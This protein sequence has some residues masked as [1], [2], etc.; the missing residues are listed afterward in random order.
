MEIFGKKKFSSAEEEIAFLRSEVARRE[1]ELLSRNKEMDHAD[2]E[3]IG[4]EVIREYAEHDPT[5]VLD[6]KHTLA[7][8]AL[9]ESHQ[10]VETAT[11]K[12][13]E[14]M[15]IA[16]EKGIRNALSVLEKMKDPFLTDE[17]HRHMV[18]VLRTESRVADLDEGGPLW[19]VLDMT[20]YEISLPR[21]P[22]ESA[23]NDIKTIFS[24]ME[25]FYAGMQTISNGKSIP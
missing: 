9:A 7:P 10:H 6:K 18:A 11:H 14:V 2:R 25:Q 21:H 13:E 16:H 23:E 12:V 1:Q 20:L 8:H 17:V 3:T 24:G 22:D 19:K 4:T 5:L 15:S